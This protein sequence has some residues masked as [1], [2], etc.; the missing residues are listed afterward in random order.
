MSGSAGRAG[1]AS[2]AEVRR[3]KNRKLK[4]LT[5]KARQIL[6]KDR[7]EEKSQPVTGRQVAAVRSRLAREGE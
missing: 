1:C 5:G 3:R 2:R 4:R 6:R 7:A